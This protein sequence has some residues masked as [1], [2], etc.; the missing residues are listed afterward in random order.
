MKNNKSNLSIIKVFKT[1][2]LLI[3]P[4]YFTKKITGNNGNEIY[5]SSVHKKNLKI[6]ITSIHKILFIFRNPKLK[7]FI[8]TFLGKFITIIGRKR[9]IKA[10]NFLPTII[11][12]ILKNSITSE[13][14]NIL[15]NQYLLLALLYKF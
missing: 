1:I 5:S 14:L 3:I 10:T 4:Y 12:I 11:Y 7:H 9:L 8:K 13:K 6:I 2:I 15:L